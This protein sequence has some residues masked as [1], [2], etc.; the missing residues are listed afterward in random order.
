V[1]HRIDEHSIDV[2]LLKGGAVLDIGCRGFGFARALA[3][4][5][6]RVIAIDPNP[7]I[8]DPKIAGVTFI[9]KALVPESHAPSKVGYEMTNDPAANFTWVD[10]QASI[11]VLHNNAHVLAVECIHIST[12]M[13]ANNIAMW[14]VIKMDCEGGEYPLLAEWPGPITRQITVEFHEHVCPRGMDTINGIVS[15]LSQWYRP[16]QHW[17]GKQHGIAAR[18][19]WDSLFCLH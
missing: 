7:S 3:E 5:G 8:D 12:L 17:L 14:D 13:K 10:G 6:C 15:H 1:I 11:H 2:D 19:Y 9:N 4:L 18:N 16:A